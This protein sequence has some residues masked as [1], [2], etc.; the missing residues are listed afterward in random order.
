ME[1]PDARKRKTVEQKLVVDLTKCY[2]CGGKATAT[3]ATCRIAV[4]DDHQQ[5]GLGSFSVVM[6]TM[7]LECATVMRDW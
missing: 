2:V 5:E 6:A 4:C 1:K 3:C 7:C